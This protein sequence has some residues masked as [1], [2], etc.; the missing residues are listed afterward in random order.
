MFVIAIT[1]L[2]V[3]S[4]ALA[5]PQL[6]GLSATTL[7]RS[8]RL[9]LTGT[10]FGAS[11]GSSQ[12]LIDGITAIV[13]TWSSTEIHAYVPESASIA[14]V[15]VQ[16]MA[17]GIPSNV[18][19]VTV[20]LR[21]PNGRIRWRFQT[22]DY[23]PLQFVARGSNGI[24]YVSDWAGLYALSPD[25]GLQWFVK[26]AGGG[27]PISFGADGTIYTGGAQGTLVWAVN[28]DGT[29]QWIIPNNSGHTLLAG[30]NIGPD[31]NLYAVQDANLELTEGLG[32]FSLD[33][34]GNVRFS[35]RQFWSN[36]GGNSEITFGEGQWYGS[37]EFN[38]SGPSTIH[39]FDMDNGNLLWDAGDVGVSAL[40]YPVVDSLG[41]LLL[42][43]AGSGIV[44]VTPDGQ[45]DWIVDYPYASNVVLQPVV[46][47][48]GIAYA[49]EFF[50]VGLWALD[51]GGN[52]VWLAPEIPNSN[53]L[54]LSVSPDETILLAAG[55]GGFGY[56]GHARGYSTTDGSLVWHVEL[57]SENGANQFISCWSAAFTPDSQTA[58]FSTH[59]AGSVNDFGYVYAMAVPFDPALDRD[60]DGYADVD[61]NCPNVP[62]EDQ[63][64]SDGDGIGD[65]C[66]F[67]SDFCQEAIPI[68]PGSY[69]GATA[70]ATTDGASTCTQFETGNRDVW[71]SYTPATSGSVTIDT[72]D[73]FWSN[74]ISIHTGC[75]GTASNQVACNSYCCQGLSCLTFNATGGQTYLIRLTGFNANEI[76]YTLNLSGP[77]CDAN[78]I[79]GDGIPNKQDNCPA[80]A[81]P[82]QA[83]CDGNGVGD[84]CAIATGQSSDCEGNGV[85]DE[86]QIPADDCNANGTPDVCDIANNGALDCDSNGVLDACEGFPG[87]DNNLCE[88]ATPLCP[89]SVLG[90]TALATNDGSVSCGAAGNSPDVWY[91][92]TAEASGQATVSTCGSWYD[93]FLSAHTGCPGTAANQIACNDDACGTFDSLITFGVIAGETYLIRVSGYNGATGDF[94]LD[95]V[96]PNCV[97]SGS[98]TGDLNGDGIVDAIDVE[99]FVGV[100]IGVDTDPTRFS[101]CDLNQDGL[102]NG[103]DVPVMVFE[104]V[105]GS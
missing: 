6:A 35:Q 101:N 14:T 78:D 13:T 3:A 22:D 39:V 28:P 53:L 80:H 21:Q 45:P 100:L 9:V 95:L 34:G 79:D 46:G 5:Q 83:D 12:V 61:D 57:P 11:Q 48:S 55:S 105:N 73:S 4:A 47:A 17:S 51:P 87:C 7:D 2:G 98:I 71:Y 93:T 36:A 27:R 89:G 90:S 68:C 92:Y 23:V 1:T 97:P 54:R 62:N 88:N 26:G 67:L 24:V 40:G 81:N 65:A 76:V 19:A 42:S 94:V 103:K 75:P 44:A 25:G 102:V 15:P 59:F 58:Y 43:R 16:V 31:G 8:G 52:T 33:S 91:S 49:G 85:P 30:P 72:C 60:A 29:V 10:G 69:V 18:L 20:T 99:I 41:R 38:P 32:Q 70:G 74:T 64:D 82:A 63:I 104:A 66:D 50:N 77:S 84:V 96:G 37:W 86:C 56:T